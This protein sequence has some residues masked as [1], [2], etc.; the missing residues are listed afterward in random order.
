MYIDVINT[1]FCEQKSYYYR[2]QYFTR[3]FNVGE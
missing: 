2:R 3:L 1:V